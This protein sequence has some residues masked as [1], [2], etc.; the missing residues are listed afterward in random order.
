MGSKNNPA[1][2][3]TAGGIKKSK[4]QSSESLCFYVGKYAGHGNYMA[5]QFED[6]KMIDSFWRCQHRL[7]IS[8]Q[9]RRRKHNFN[10]AQARARA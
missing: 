10:C 2:R 9:I 6:G 1:A 5:G 8:F 4:R 7:R 3:G